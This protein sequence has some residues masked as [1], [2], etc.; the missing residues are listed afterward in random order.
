MV[1][2]L[3]WEINNPTLGPVKTNLQVS[4]L[5][6]P[7]RSEDLAHLLPNWDNQNRITLSD[8]PPKLPSRQVSWPPRQEEESLLKRRP[9][10]HPRPKTRRRVDWHPQP[11]LLCVT[12]SSSRMLMSPSISITSKWGRENWEVNLIQW[13][14]TTP[15]AEPV[16]LFQEDH[17]CQIPTLA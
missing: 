2:T 16:Q 14:W 8:L 11:Q 1:M 12:P 3:E 10:E 13:V 4:K 5:V 6:E 15:W 17:Q 9:M 7:K